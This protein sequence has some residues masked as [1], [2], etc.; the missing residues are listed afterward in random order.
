MKVHVKSVFDI[1]TL[2]KVSDEFVEYDGPVELCKG[3]NSQAQMAISNQIAQQQLGMQQQVFGE[4][5]PT[6]KNIIANGGMLPGQEAALRA[7]T[8]N[9]LP[10][11][12]N[13]LYG[14]LAQQLTARGLTGGQY[15]AGG[16]GVAA[17]YGSLGAQEAGQAQQ[18]EFNIAA[19][20]QQGLNSALGL[21][22]A[23]IS[24]LGNQGVSANQTAASAAQA[25][26]QAQTGFW[27]S[28]FG[29]L[30]AG[31]GGWAGGGFKT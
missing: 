20:K 11:T 15:G 21:G 3:D 25:A 14:N 9:A 18:G 24:S 19:L 8:I 29:A 23:N 2:I 5:N 12:Y 1:E 13:N 17:G 7:Q 28:L 27:G 22:N 10:Q 26:D 4:V 31:V 6:I 30:G 16:G